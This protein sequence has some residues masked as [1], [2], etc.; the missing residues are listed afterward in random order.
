[1]APE[2]IQI[3]EAEYSAE[4]R[5]AGLEGTVF[6]TGVVDEDG[7]VRDAQLTRGL[8][9]GLDEIAIRKVQQWHFTPGTFQAGPLVIP[10]DC[11]VPSKQSR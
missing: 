4:G 11:L 9:F 5:A 8:G 6:I 2:R 7:S 3:S 10:V 1:M